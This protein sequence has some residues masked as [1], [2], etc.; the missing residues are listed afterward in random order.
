MEMKLQPLDVKKSREGV[1]FSPMMNT[2]NASP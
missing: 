1:L 2:K